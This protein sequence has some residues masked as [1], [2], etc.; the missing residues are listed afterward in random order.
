MTKN[1][2]NALKHE[3]FE[4]RLLSVAHRGEQF[5]RDKGRGISHLVAKVIIVHHVLSYY[6]GDM[7]KRQF[8]ICMTVVN[9]QVF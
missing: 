7:L 5:Y 2:Q 3:S 8:K 4:K 6:M 9:S 1:A